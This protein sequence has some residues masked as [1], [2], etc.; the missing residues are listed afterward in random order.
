MSQT[1]HRA[2][3]MAAALFV[4]AL[5]APG[6]A[7]WAQQGGGTGLPGNT[8]VQI[9][10]ILVEGQ[11]RL[12][13][14]VIIGESGLRTG[15]SVTYRETQRAI[16]RLWASG[17]YQ[18]VQIGVEAEST[19]PGAPVTLVIRVIEQPY[20]STVEFRGLENVSASTVRDSAGLKNPGPL[21]PARVTHAEATVRKLLA[22]KGYRLE[23]ISHR[24]EELPD[25][26][27]E[28]R[29]VFDVDE[30]QRVAIAEIVF[31]GNQALSD[32]QLRKVLGTR[33]EGFLW[34]RKGTYDEGKLRDDLR[35]TLPA[36]YGRLG[37][38]DFTVTGD[39]LVVDPVSGKA[40]L[41]ISVD[42]GPQ[43]RLAGFDIRGNSRFPTEDLT[44][45]FEKQQ[46]GLLRR[47]GLGR[48][49]IRERGEVFDRSAFESAIEQIHSLYRTY[50]YIYAQVEP[51]IERTTGPDGEPAVDLAL[52][53]HEG[54]PAYINRVMITGNT[55]THEDV[56]RERISL[57]PGAVYNEEALIQSYQSIMGLG[58]FESP[59]PMPRMEQNPETGDVD[60]T[61]EVKEKQTG[62]IN[63]GTS[64]GGWGGVAGFL[65][66]DQPNLFGQA[67]SGHLRWEFG[68]YSNNFETSYS[69]PS[70]AGSR[71]SGSL[72]LFNTKYGYGKMFQFNE[73]EQ[74][75]TGAGLRFGI[76][77]PLD[78]FYSRIFVG[79]SLTR[80]KY[81]QFAEEGASL[82]D[83]PTSLKSSVS[84]G[85]MRQRLDH[86]LFPTSGSHQELEASFSGGPLGGNSAFQKYTFTGSWWVP[87]GKLGGTQP[88]TRPI[89]F[90]LGLS[91]DA[92]AL[93]GDA[94]RFP[95]ERFWL[96]GVQFG[97]PLRGYD[98]TT[99]TPNGYF[100]REDRS[101]ALQ[102][103]MGDAYVRLSA[104]Y[105]IRLNDNISTSL[106]YEA[107]NVW[108]RAVEIN[109]TRLYR[110][111][112]VGL[113]LITPFGPIGLDYAYGFDR[114]DP[115]WKLH[116]KFGQGF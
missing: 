39:S 22:N 110:S 10:R 67:K 87:V 114:T 76:P 115:G 104:E 77:F 62:S 7:L 69:D 59:M 9:E 20:V 53:I 16:R 4:A 47:V 50:G 56:I 49:E 5:A 45:Y 36:H 15:E 81:T 68:R 41:V 101:I 18:D 2:A 26:P 1:G 94:S 91:A 73:G 24:L 48:S 51:V 63:F 70:I 64:V 109:P 61:F 32:D 112:G 92:G 27:G 42:E 85:L 90:A 111:A 57:L 75:Q 14:A 3:A 25:R 79:Y 28:H 52:E 86:P 106:F 29:L 107:G 96:G 12:N 13:E 113:T 60:I 98:E 17:Q 116:F 74:R 55:F 35:Q 88:G 19:D 78:P 100:P 97:K 40:R 72:S 66:Y 38:I 99:I 21:R 95:F 33:A 6:A 34:F 82:F 103:R 30:G 108:R 65:G 89:R 54:G 80:A 8:A 23:S 83:I 37:Y 71:I 31:E 105:A 58:F 44:R 84:V 93:F 43:Y 102:D 46:G 11:S